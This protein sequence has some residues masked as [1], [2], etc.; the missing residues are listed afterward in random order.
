MVNYTIVHNIEDWY[1][2]CLNF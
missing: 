1:A 2:K